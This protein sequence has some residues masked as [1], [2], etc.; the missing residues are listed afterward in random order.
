MPET[1]GPWS[2]FRD[3]SLVLDLIFFFGPCAEG[4]EGFGVHDMMTFKATVLV[5]QG[6]LVVDEGI[7]EI[8]GFRVM[9]RRSVAKPADSG[10]IYGAKAHRTRLTGAIDSSVLKFE[11]L[12]LLTGDSYGRYFSMGCGVAC[13]DYTVRSGGEHLSS[14]HNDGSKRTSALPDI[15]HGKV[16]RHLHICGV[17]L[18][19]DFFFNQFA[20][21]I[22]KF[23]PANLRKNENLSLSLRPLKSSANHG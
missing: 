15:V 5:W 10:P 7:I 4:N 18:R 11:G 23:P 16:Y 17:F 20:H 19:E 21:L 3:F 13:G 8:Y 9:F 14:A 2:T 22:S 6:E 12:H 1:L